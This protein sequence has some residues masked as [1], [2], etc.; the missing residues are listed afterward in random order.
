MAALL[1]LAYAAYTDVRAR[2]VDV[3]AVVA[4]G[5]VA[6]WS[7]ASARLDVAYALSLI[8]GAVVALVKRLA[9]SG[10]GDS[11]AV[12][13]IGA[14]YTPMPTSM[15]VIAFTG[16]PLLAT[17]VWLAL[18]NRRRRCV[19]GFAVF[20]HYCAS[21]RE[22]VEQPHRFAPIGARDLE[23]VD[24]DEVRR[25]GVEAG[26]RGVGYVAVKYGVPY[27]AHLA[28][29]YAAYVVLILTAWSL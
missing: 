28:V 7:A 12:A 23:R 13:L 11:L 18:V 20:T 25:L 4:L 24:L 22:L 15:M 6:A 9:G 3:R 26:G 27:V 19:S 2:L 14:I 1:P 5:A 29:A 8:V 17:M 21:P 16:V 10:L